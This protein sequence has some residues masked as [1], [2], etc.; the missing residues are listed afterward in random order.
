MTKWQGNFPVSNW[1][2]VYKLEQLHRE[3]RS[4]RERFEERQ[5]RLLRLSTRK[6]LLREQVSE[7][8]FIANQNG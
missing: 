2:S 5:R 8:A 6:P 7:A 1:L 4:R 3:A